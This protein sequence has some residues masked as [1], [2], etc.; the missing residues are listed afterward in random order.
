M[1]C[2]ISNNAKKCFIKLF[3]F[4]I[5][6]FECNCY[7]AW[8]CKKKDD[9]KGKHSEWANETKEEC[10]RKAFCTK[11]SYKMRKG[12]H[13]SSR[14][15][16]KTVIEMFATAQQC[17]HNQWGHFHFSI[18]D[19]ALNQ[20]VYIYLI[21]DWALT[22]YML[23]TEQRHNKNVCQGSERKDRISPLSKTAVTANVRWKKY[24]D[25]E[26]KQDAGRIKAYKILN[27]K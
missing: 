3:E 2:N 21:A 26:E 7:W 10:E 9:K 16:F 6:A 19:I 5:I 18:I 17:T 4:G 25:D 27:G 12:M 15:A 8:Q 23:C 20:Y 14:K 11:V 22:N 24:I 13:H 1:S